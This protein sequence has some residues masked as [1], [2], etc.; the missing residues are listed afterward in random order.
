MKFAFEIA[1]NVAAQRE[2]LIKEMVETTISCAEVAFAE[3]EKIGQYNIEVELPINMTYEHLRAEYE[4][5]VVRKFEN[6]DYLIAYIAP[7]KWFISCDPSAW[8]GE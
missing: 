5:E 3:A 8:E 7:W 2:R 4:E 1:Y 6:Y